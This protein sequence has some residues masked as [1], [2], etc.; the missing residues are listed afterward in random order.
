M[1][2]S[3]QDLEVTIL[4]FGLLFGFIMGKTDIRDKM[5]AEVEKNVPVSVRSFNQTDAEWLEWSKVD[6]EELKKGD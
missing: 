2:M 3:L 6:V 4:F 5:P 1:F